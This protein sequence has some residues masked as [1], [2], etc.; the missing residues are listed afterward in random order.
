MWNGNMWEE[1][2]LLN[3]FSLRNG[4]KLFASIERRNRND[5]LRSKYIIIFSLT[6][7]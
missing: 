2:L 3:S 7:V 6:P 4:G 5:T 1:L